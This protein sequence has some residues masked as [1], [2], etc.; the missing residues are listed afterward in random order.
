MEI[1]WKTQKMRSER[2][3]AKTRA[4]P[5]T[6]IRNYVCNHQNKLGNNYA[7]GFG[8]EI[9]WV[10]LLE[11]MNKNV[12]NY[13][14]REHVTLHLWENKDNFELNSVPAPPE[15][16]YPDLRFD[17]DEPKDLEKLKK[18]CYNGINID[19]TAHEIVNTVLSK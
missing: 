19:S 17:V 16:A 6:E 9:F 5:A 12:N 14:Q 7:D 11:S 13:F 2:A 15:L 10:T 8:A 3:G 1:Q 18:I 4:C